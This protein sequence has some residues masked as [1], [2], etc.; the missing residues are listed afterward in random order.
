MSINNSRLM[1]V[2]GATDPETVLQANMETLDD[3]LYHLRPSYQAGVPTTIKGPPTGGTFVINSLWRDALGA[4]FACTVAGTPGT[5]VQIQPAVVSANPTGIPVGYVIVR[6]DENYRLFTYSG[7]GFV[8]TYLPL[9]GG[10]LTG[11]VI[12]AADPTTALGLATKG[13]VD[14][15][16]GATGADPKDSCVAASTANIN[17]AAGG[18]LTIDGVVLNAGDRVLVKDQT[19]TTQNGIYVAAVGT[20]NRSADTATSAQVTSGM[21][22]HVVGGTVNAATGWILVAADPV[23]LGTTALTFSPFMA[24]LNNGQVTDPKIGNRTINQALA[25][26]GNTGALTDLLSWLA[27]QI[28]AIKGT[29]NWYDTPQT[30]L[31]HAAEVVILILIDDG[32]PALATGDKR[33]FEIS[34]AGT[35]VGWTIV[36]NAAGSIT[37]ALKKDTYA[38]YPPTTDMTNGNYPTLA[39]AQKNQ[40]LAL[41]GWTTTTVAAGEWI[42][43]SVVTTSGLGWAV[44]SL[45]IRKT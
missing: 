19:T 44:L 18:L 40:N 30:N 45:R 15:L 31:A 2:S 25:T 16:L 43:P 28:V 35:I 10:T 23:T 8:E 11:P 24:F 13:Y 26:P 42:L 1:N 34:F 36:G 29:T 32:T 4:L 41:A 20:W 27:G 17:L 33:P 5:W 3:D 39:T 6:A 38:N 37:V 14:A 9:A 21:F 22:V 12:A 7:T